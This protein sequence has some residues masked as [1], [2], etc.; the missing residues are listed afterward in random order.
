MGR[1]GRPLTR[2]RPVRLRDRIRCRRRKSKSRSVQMSTQIRTLS[3]DVAVGNGN[4]R[5]LECATF[6]GALSGGVLPEPA[7]C[8]LLFGTGAASP[9]GIAVPTAL[10]FATPA[11]VLEFAAFAEGGAAV[12]D[13]VVLMRVTKLAMPRTQ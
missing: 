1:L 3:G 12:P 9:P 10:G 4:G 13:I 5:V 6:H 8:G 2:R 11:A 7:S